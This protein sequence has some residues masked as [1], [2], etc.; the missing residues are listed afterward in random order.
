MVIT[1]LPRLRVE[2][3]NAYRFDLAVPRPRHGARRVELEGN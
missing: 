1:I 2:P 3:G